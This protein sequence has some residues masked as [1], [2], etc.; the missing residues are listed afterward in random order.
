MRDVF[1]RVAMPLVVI[2]LLT[3][4]C[5]SDVVRL[6]DC[7]DCRPVEMTM[8]QTF[9]ADVGWGIRPGQREI[10]YQVVVAD[11][12]TMQLVSTE[13]IERS[14]GPDEFVGGVSHGVIMRFEPT[15]VGT[16]TIVFETQDMEGNL[17]TD[18]A[19]G[20]RAVLEITVEVSE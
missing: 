12:G 4:S 13:L 17:R 6:P 19:A 7:E 5:S 1:L 20:Q 18:L 11:P 3:T 9:E 15:G 10:E 16:T 2:C 14:E 8:D